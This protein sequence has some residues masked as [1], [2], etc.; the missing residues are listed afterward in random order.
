MKRRKFL[1]TTV[2]V[3]GGVSLVGCTP[4]PA[5]GPALDD[6]T[7]P[8]PFGGRD[9]RDG[10]QH[11]PQSVASGDPRQSS[12]IL[13]ARAE[14]NDVDGD[15]T[16][17]LDVALDQAFA[18][19]VPLGERASVKAEVAHDGC[20]RIRVDGLEPNTVYFYR[21][22]YIRGQQALVSR[23]GRTK[24]A[25]A[26]DD[27]VSVHFAVASCHDYGG[28]Y[29]HA[30]K[31]MAKQDLDFFVHLGDYVYETTGD[32]S[33]QATTGKRRVKF[34]DP[35]SAIALGEEGARYFAAS[36][37]DHYRELYKT[38]RSDPDLQRV[39]ELFPMIAVWDDHEFSDDAHGQTATYF[40]G[41]K[42]ERDPTR[43]ANAD[44]AW[45]EFMPVDYAE[46]DF[47]YDSTSAAFPA[48]LTI[49]RDFVFGQHVHLVMT[50]LR[51]YRDDHLVAEDAF[52]GAIA[53]TEA[54]LKQA[55]GAVPEYA[56][57]YLD[58]DDAAYASHKT[59]LNDHAAE[60]DFVS[61]DFTGPVDIA[62]VNRQLAKLNVEPKPTALDATGAA[63]GVSFSSMFKSGRHSQ[64]GSRYVL[65]SE[66]FEGYARVLWDVSAGKAQQ[67]LGEQQEQ[68]FFDTVRNSKSTWKVWGNGFTFMRRRVD[69]RDEAAASA[70]GLQALLTLS[71]EDWDGVP[72]RR[73][74]VIDNLGGVPN[75]V[76][77]SGDIHAFFA[78]V[79]ENDGDSTQGILEFVAGAISSA[80]YFDLLNAT[81]LTISPLAGAL[82]ENAE[83]LLAAAN[84]H[85]AHI[86][87][88]RNGYGVFAASAATL[89]VT[90]YAVDG[91][92][93]LK[94][95]L[96]G[97][98]EK[99]FAKTSFRVE[100]GK[101]ALLRDRN[102]TTQRWD[103]QA[104][105][106]V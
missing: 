34:A 33:F 27:D 98:L 41:A 39:H 53:A 42:N 96:S 10:V 95:T 44:Q 99:S 23:S 30:Y 87:L 59:Y 4:S 85:L 82:A 88:R 58:L 52:P 17:E 29:Y 105:A 12:V 66:P 47:V 64:I 28:R 24:T 76:A 36:G 69:L 20:V 19:R 94:S 22:A 2:L 55:L 11:F 67:I 68:W 57:P 31:H 81:A 49:Y 92:A 1:K 70:I 26:A 38:F 101:R 77:V 97:G 21:F 78:G 63:R 35:A 54:E 106:W 91:A 75:L 46:P 60:L 50:D 51:R 89:S 6:G 56:I 8:P 16:I 79:A 71:A 102:G 100:A 104:G 103:A 13:W 14:D 86:D 5:A 40:A 90:F 80:C 84:P 83:P 18:M 45:F 73:R 9:V 15:L 62:F 7:P 3:A 32:P 43:R 37:L 61:G 25:P 65:P 74:K 93:V 48:D 72:D